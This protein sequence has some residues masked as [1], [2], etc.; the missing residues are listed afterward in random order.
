[1]PFPVARNGRPASLTGAFDSTAARKAFP[2]TAALVVLVVLPFGF[3]SYFL[4][5][6]NAVVAPQIVA[7]R[8]P[9]KSVH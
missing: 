4:R 2:G 5:N 9:R 8:P 7:D 3:L 1:M 6:V